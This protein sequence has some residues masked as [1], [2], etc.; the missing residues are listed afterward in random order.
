LKENDLEIKVLVNLIDSYKVRELEP[1]RMSIP[2]V[3]GRLGSL[4]EEGC[5]NILQYHIPKTTKKR[6]LDG[7]R[8]A[9]FGW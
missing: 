3:F 1:Q 9:G 7:W 4:K 8:N 6:F 5:L 2:P